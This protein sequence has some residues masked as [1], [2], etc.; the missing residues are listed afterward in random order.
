MVRSRSSREEK[1]KTKKPKQP[2]S[3]SKRIP[4][5]AVSS[6]DTHT[7]THTHSHTH[8]LTHSLTHPLTITHT[9]N[10][11]H[12]HT[13]THTH[14]QG[15][16][17][18]SPSPRRLAPQKRGARTCENAVFDCLRCHPPHGQ[19]RR[20]AGGVKMDAGVGGVCMWRGFKVRVGTR[21][22]VQE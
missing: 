14:K 13:I 8:S 1:N 22:S 15:H 5:N 12:T 21:K 20:P 19:W 4:N 2:R 10:H 3:V 18:P 16:S 11:K 17:L 9:H 7:H 6:A